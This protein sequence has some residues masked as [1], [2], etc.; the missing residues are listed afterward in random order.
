[1]TSPG[2]I[3]RLTAPLRRA[4]RTRGF[5]VH[6]PFAYGYLNSVIR[7][8][9]GAR[10]YAEDRLHGARAR[11]L[12]RVGVEARGSVG[13]WPADRGRPCATYVCLSR[14]DIPSL[15]TF[16]RDHGVGVLFVGRHMAI[17]CCREGIPPLRLNVWLPRR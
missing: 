14:N 8:R 1:M 10:Y 7:P 16:A 2:I 9:G 4:W 5:G 15:E 17:Y 13:E 3:R 11:L 6:S 12:Y